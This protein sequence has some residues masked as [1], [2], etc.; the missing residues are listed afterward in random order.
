MLT[1]RDPSAMLSCNRIT[2][3]LLVVVALS[4]AACSTPMGESAPNKQ[5]AGPGVVATQ[6]KTPV[7]PPI[8][9]CCT[10]PDAQ[11]QAE[12]L[13]RQKAAI[14]QRTIY[15]AY[16]Q[17]RVADEYLPIVEAHARYML[18]N[19]KVV[20]RVTGNA[21]E[22]GSREYNLALGQKRAEYVQRALAIY[23]VAA[24]RIEAISYGA[25]K[26]VATGSDEA[27]WQLNRRAELNYE[28]E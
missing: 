4:M 20:L 17:Y 19:P 9:T 2:A 13:A 18:G 8:P 26:P 25:E 14:S 12:E 23:G 15:F 7:Q 11:R 10:N 27:S 16:D 21:D 3:T 6:D 22:R 1:S 24:Q 28:H 5:A